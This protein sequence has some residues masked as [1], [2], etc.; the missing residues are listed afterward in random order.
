MLNSEHT[1]PVE[2]AMW[3]LAEVLRNSTGQAHSVSDCLGYF[4]EAG[5]REV[6][7][8][9]FVPGTLMRAYGRRAV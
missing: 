6:S 8:N 9:E 2:P 1:E 4:E 3:G 7:M 5:F